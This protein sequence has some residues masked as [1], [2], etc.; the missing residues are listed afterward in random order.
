MNK[1]VIWDFFKTKGFTDCG[2]AGLMG[3]IYVE[4]GFNPQN[5]EGK[6]NN[7]LKM[8]DDEYTKAVDSGAYSYDLFQRDTHGFGLV[9]WTYHT[10]KAALFNYAKKCNKSIG[11]LNMQL[12]FLYGELKGYPS[13]F[14]ALQTAT[15]VR[16]ASDIVM[17]QYERPYDQSEKARKGRAEY[18][19]AIYYEF[20]KKLVDVKL[21][22]LRKRCSGDSVKAL[23]ILLNGLGYDCG[24]ADG[25]FGDKT[26]KAVIAFQK[27]NRLDADGIVGKDTWT[28]IL[29]G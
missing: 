1:K 6:G 10:R 19:E 9:Q 4:S 12:E 27:K 18:G 25:E 22:V 29:N 11:D 14:K 8:T 28:V 24:K 23:Q 20:C 7:A 16:E 2:I 3:N 21:P 26:E 5:L 17:L 15:T 13:V